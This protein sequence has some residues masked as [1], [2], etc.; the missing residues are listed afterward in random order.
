[1]SKRG[2]ILI[3]LIISFL[4]SPAFSQ[5]AEPVLLSNVNDPSTEDW[6]PFLTEDGLT[7]YF[8]RV[9]TSDSYYGRLY[10]AIRDEPVGPFTIVRKVPDPINSPGNEHFLCPWVSCDNLR[11]Y[12]NSQKSGVGWKLKFSQRASTSE[13][14]PLGTD[15]IEL[16]NVGKYLTGPKLSGDELLIFFQAMD[17][18][19]SQHDIWMASRTDRNLP[20][21]YVR[22]LDEIN[23]SSNEA[24]PNVSPDGLILYF[25]SNRNGLEQLFK[26]TRESRNE[27]FGNVEH[28][29]FFDTDNGNSAQFC[30]SS[31]EKAIYFVRSKAGNRS[32]QDI[33]ISY[34]SGD[35]STYHNKL[36]TG[37]FYEVLDINE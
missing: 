10:E 29:S 1:M 33:Y 23:T 6:S 34:Y 35:T 27:S 36:S 11:M 30:F 14:W 17:R 24:H 20:F 8:V 25:T 31:D 22:K 26:A 7:L 12:Y 28:M 13:P 32:T 15:V 16:N 19:G 18:P 37:F 5:W 9:R 4:I 3:I 2:S 21:E